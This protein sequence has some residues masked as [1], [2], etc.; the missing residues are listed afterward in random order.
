[1]LQAGK[2]NRKVSLSNATTTTPDADGMFSALTPEIVWA[3]IQPAPPQGVGDRAILHNVTIR[4]H[5]QV[6]L[7]TRLIYED[8]LKGTRQLFVRGIQ[9]VD[10]QNVEMRLLCEEVI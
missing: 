9:N 4:Y 7:E 1:M 2:L 6:G 5:A 10:E 3:A 8:P